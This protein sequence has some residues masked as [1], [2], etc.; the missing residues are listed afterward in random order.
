MADARFAKPLDTDL[1]SRLARNHEVLIT[2]EEG[3]VGGFGSACAAAPGQRRRLLDR[4]LKVRQMV[5]PDA[6]IDHDKPE[7]MYERAG[8]NASGIVATVLATLGPGDPCQK[9]GGAR[10]IAVFSTGSPQI[11]GAAEGRRHRSLWTDNRRPPM[12]KLSLDQ[13]S[14][15]PSYPPSGSGKKPWRQRRGFTPASASAGPPA[16][17]A[18]GRAHGRKRDPA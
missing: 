12:H 9:F 13:L 11:S 1:I 15:L 18:R 4:G 6:F 8:L 10:L 16:D 2:I 7:K 17:G 5:L 3:S 14:C